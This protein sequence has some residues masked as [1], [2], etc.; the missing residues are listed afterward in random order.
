MQ[1]TLVIAVG[2]AV[3]VIGAE[4]TAA[5]TEHEIFALYGGALAA[6][7][8]TCQTSAAPITEALSGW[9]R[10]A[11]I[12]QAELQLLSRAFDQA[13]NNFA[14]STPA[15]GCADMPRLIEEYRMKLGQ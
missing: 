5:A 12:N 11:K 7:A 1:K 14:G 8:S 2:L 3:G 6:E 10:D 9:M 15:R 13:R 4:A